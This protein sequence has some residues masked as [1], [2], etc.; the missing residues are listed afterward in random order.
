MFSRV[1]PRDAQLFIFWLSF[2]DGIPTGEVTHCCTA[3]HNQQQLVIS[4]YW[5]LKYVL[6]T[7][8]GR[9]C[10]LKLRNFLYKSCTKLYTLFLE[11]FWRRFSV[12]N[13]FSSS[14]SFL[15]SLFRIRSEILYTCTT[16]LQI[17]KSFLSRIKA[18]LYKWTHS[19]CKGKRGRIKCTS[20]SKWDSARHMMV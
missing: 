3:A 17:D 4:K 7:C 2:H 16:H 18:F 5:H 6:A 15:T 20:S 13:S 1:F 19:D 14:E 10:N 9:I 12:R 8:T 11:N